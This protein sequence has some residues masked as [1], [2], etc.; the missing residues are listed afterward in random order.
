MSTP[1]LPTSGAPS[2]YQRDPYTGPP[3]VTSS[4][5]AR[6]VGSWTSGPSLRHSATTSSGVHTRRIGGGSPSVALDGRLG[7]GDVACRMVAQHLRIHAPKMWRR[8]A[9]FPWLVTRQQQCRAVRECRFVSLV[10]SCLQ[11]TRNDRQ[12]HRAARPR[13]RTPGIASRA[14]RFGARAQFPATASV[15][16]RSKRPDVEARRLSHEGHGCTL[17]HQPCDRGG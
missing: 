7:I 16:P 3:S 5:A 4:S 14:P 8:V 11:I 1:V 13:R 15:K 12:V 9:E 10:P 17:L 2:R 6:P